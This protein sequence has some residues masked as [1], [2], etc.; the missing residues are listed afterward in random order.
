[1][2]L[3][4]G[5]AIIGIKILYPGRFLNLLPLIGT[6][7]TGIFIVLPKIGQFGQF[8]MQFMNQMPNVETV[9]EI[10][11]EYDIAVTISGLNITEV[12]DCLEEIR[13]LKGVANTNTMIVLHS[14]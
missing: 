10:T 11:G 13:R 8:R 6:F 12:N 7:A 9:Y 3:A 4:I 14:W 2:Y 5:G 1:M